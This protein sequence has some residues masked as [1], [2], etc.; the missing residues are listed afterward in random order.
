MPANP[1][2]LLNYVAFTSSCVAVV[3]AEGTEKYSTM[4]MHSNVEMTDVEFDLCSSTLYW[5]W[6][7]IWCNDCV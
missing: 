5:L 3:Y 7:N 6:M 1:L 2:G 4:D